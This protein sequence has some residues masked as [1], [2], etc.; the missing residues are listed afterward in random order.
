MIYPE[1]GRG[2]G[3]TDMIVENK[4]VAL[5]CDMFQSR[6]GGEG[7]TQEFAKGPARGPETWCLKDNLM[8]ADS[9]DVL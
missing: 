4:G 8:I 5:T 9:E 6:S 3:Q 2:C 1:A 7:Q